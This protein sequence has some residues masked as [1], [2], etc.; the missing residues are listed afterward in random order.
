M[1]KNSFL[2]KFTSTIF[3]LTFATIQT[4]CFTNART[5]LSG[6]SKEQSKINN[7]L[8]K[9]KSGLSAKENYKSAIET[10]IKEIQNKIDNENKKLDEINST[11]EEKQNS[12]NNIQAD[13]DS[14]YAQLKKRVCVIY[15]AGDTSL[16]EILMESKNFTDLMDKADFIQKISK[17]NQDI[18]NSLNLDIQK[19]ASEKAIIEE[20]KNQIDS[21]VKSLDDN[22]NKLEQAEKE[23][24][25]NIAEL[26]N[27]QNKKQSRL[28][29]IESEKR[30]LEN[31]MSSY[32]RNQTS[33]ANVNY[34][35]GRYVWPAPNCHVITSP[36]GPRWGSFHSGIDIS[37]GRAYGS[38][39]VAACDG[40]VIK[41]NSTNSWGSGWGYHVMIDHGNGYATLYA[42]C[43]TVNVRAG[44]QVK[45]GQVIARIGNT[46]HSF[47]AHLHFE[48]WH[49][50]KRYN[51]TTEL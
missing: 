44:Q 28:K 39:I 15:K 36:Y 3:C 37:G 41:A 45:A 7:E 14:K 38:P 10:Q 47:G 48:T 11:I 25:K 30:T 32:T 35:N 40:V 13:I 4:P 33:R 18:I 5:T 34:K 9:I 31:Q 22:K 12:I 21:I 6:L 19:V 42:H 27:S 17:Y 26:K 8:K 2:I 24:E 43:S 20:N 29:Q 46:G 1:K 51:P 50:G 49:D 16:I 23:N